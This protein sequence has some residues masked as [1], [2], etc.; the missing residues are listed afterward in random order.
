MISILDDAYVYFKS[1]ETVRTLGR[2]F[3]RTLTTIFLTI[4]I[5]LRQ[6]LLNFH[7]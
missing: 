1:H 4:M 7:Q 3:I 6:P 2:V 5:D